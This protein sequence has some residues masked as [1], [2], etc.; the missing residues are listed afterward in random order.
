MMD[1]MDLIAKHFGKESGRDLTK[2]D[3]DKFIEEYLQ[4]MINNTCRRMIRINDEDTKELE[5]YKRNKNNLDN[6]KLTKQDRM[7]AYDMIFYDDE[8][9]IDSFLNNYKKEEK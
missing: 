2:E 3:I 7:E 1:Y 5:K 8:E 4:P 6:I 9:Q